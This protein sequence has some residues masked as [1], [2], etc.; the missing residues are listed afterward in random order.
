MSLS[1]LT[2]AV[3]LTPLLPGGSNGGVKPFI[4]EYLKWLGNQRVYPL[5]FVFLTRSSSHH[6]VRPLARFAD[7]LICILNDSEKVEVLEP[8]N[9]PAERCLFDPPEDLVARIG[10]DVVYTPFGCCKWH[11]PGVPTIATAIDALHRDYPQSL[12][13]SDVALRESLFLDLKSRADLVQCISF[14]TMDRMEQYYGIDRKRMFCSYIAIHN[15]LKS[16]TPSRKP[17][18]RLYFLFP[19]NAW[20]HKN[21]PVLLLAYGIYLKIPEIEHWDLVLTGHDDAAMRE[22]LNLAQTLG[23][24][25]RVRYLGH[26]GEKEYTSV[27]ANAGALLFPSIYEGFGI[28]LVEAMAFGQPILASR[29]GSIQ[30]V[31]GEACLYADP[32]K[33]EELAQAMFQISTDESLR[34]RLIDLGHLRLKDFSFQSDAHVFL[35]KI[36]TCARTPAR[37]AV[38]G[39]YV[40]GWT[41]PRVTFNSPRGA[42]SSDLRISV[43]PMP[44]DRTFRL[45]SEANLLT[46]RSVIAGQSGDFSIKVHADGE[47]FT[48]EVTNASSLSP[49]DHRVLGL[50]LAALKIVPAEGESTDLMAFVT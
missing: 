23:L 31:G 42:G 18:S 24:S 26:L 38:R 47:R 34:E 4:F 25:Q 43:R 15:R 13:P 30:E 48:L 22:V 32:R 36:V 12:T 6:E 50:L 27:W 8:H 2:L 3:D 21:H 40:D 9:S 37:I 16:E 17:G 20:K 10:A 7:E 11:W 29:S 49:T 35:E 33:P 39:I 41:G 46:Q 1:Q 44:A 28:P 5:R 19:A 45:Y 14:F